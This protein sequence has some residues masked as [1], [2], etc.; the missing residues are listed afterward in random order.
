MTSVL[1]KREIWTQAQ[2]G[3]WRTPCAKTGRDWVLQLLVQE[4]Q[5][6]RQAP[7]AGRT[8]IPWSL[9]RDGGPAGTL[10]S[11]LLSSECARIDFYHFKPP[12]LW[13]F[14]TATLGN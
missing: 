13:S 1:I 12:S 10:T 9:Q 7:G 4:W 14:I 2:R 11:D 5:G 3:T 8:D 6:Q